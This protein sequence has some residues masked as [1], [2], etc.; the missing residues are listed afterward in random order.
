MKSTKVQANT[1][2]IVNAPASQA[3]APREGQGGKGNALPTMS[4]AQRQAAFQADT[5]ALVAVLES[6]GAVVKSQSSKNGPFVWR[7]YTRMSD[8]Y[9]ARDTASDTDKVIVRAAIA[10]FEAVA[11]LRGQF[12]TATFYRDSAYFGTRRE[13]SK[14]HKQ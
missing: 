8:L 1:P 4:K 13:S 14:Y 6:L 3:P 2:T 9:A 7:V 10:A 5:A 12:V 11:V